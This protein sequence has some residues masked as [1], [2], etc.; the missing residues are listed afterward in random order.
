MVVRIGKRAGIATHVHPHLLRHVYAD[1]LVR[2]TEM[3]N[4]QHLLGHTEIGTTQVYTGAPSADELLRAVADFDLTP[5]PWRGRLS[6]PEHIANPVEA[7]T[8]IEPV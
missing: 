2:Q 5:A 6:L 4:V 8:G 3:R 1:R 7:P